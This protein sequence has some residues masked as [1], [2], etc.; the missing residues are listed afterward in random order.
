[1]AGGGVVPLGVQD[2]DLAP[3]PVNLGWV[4]SLGPRGFTFLGPGARSWGFSICLSGLG[5]PA[6][7][8]TQEEGEGALLMSAVAP[9]SPLLTAGLSH[10]GRQLLHL[11]GLQMALLQEE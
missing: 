6:L 8:L 11:Q 9:P 10:P 7:M 3:S 4:W 5:A 1:M 2:I